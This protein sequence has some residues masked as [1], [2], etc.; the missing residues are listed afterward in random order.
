MK[1]GL[2]FSM[3]WLFI[4]TASSLTNCGTREDRFTPGVLVAWLGWEERSISQG[5]EGFRGGLTEDTESLGSIPPPA[6]A[7]RAV[8]WGQNC[9][10][11][12]SHA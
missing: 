2:T 8:S 11:V 3:W 9:P 6:P 4:L 1:T 12:H 5:A 10:L 7:A